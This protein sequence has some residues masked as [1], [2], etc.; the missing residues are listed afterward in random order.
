MQYKT[1]NNQEVEEKLLISKQKAI[2]FNTTN[3][4][5]MKVFFMENSSIFLILRQTNVLG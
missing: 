3:N 2:S 1:D 4:F 5:C